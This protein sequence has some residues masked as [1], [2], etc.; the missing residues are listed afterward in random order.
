M[1]ARSAARSGRRR[2]AAFRAGAP[3]ARPGRWQCGFRTSGTW[4]NPWAEVGPPRECFVSALKAGGDG[5]RKAGKGARRRSPSDPENRSAAWRV[6]KRRRRQRSL[7][8][9]ITIMW[10]PRGT[11]Q[12]ARGL[13]PRQVATRQPPF[14]DVQR[15][16]ADLSEDT[17]WP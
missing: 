17:K 14:R 16:N 7:E 6:K 4:R 8:A 15:D 13:I 11:F 1:P 3:A 10:T 5:R 12:F 9:L 2:Q